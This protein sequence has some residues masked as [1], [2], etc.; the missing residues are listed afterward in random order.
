MNEH[1]SCCS[2][3]TI[4]REK[5]MDIFKTIEVRRS[6][7]KYKP[8]AV[9]DEDLKIILQ[10]ARLAPSARNAQPWRFIVVRDHKM[11]EFL[12]QSVGNQNFVAGA[13]VVVVVLG[14]SDIAPYWYLQD[15][16][17]ATEH[18]VLAATAL[19]YGSCWIGALAD[20]VPENTGKVKQALQIPEN[21]SIVCLVTI[22][23]PDENPPP[24]PRKNLQEICFDEMYGKPLK[25]H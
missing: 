18:L 10:A 16:M 24:R 13:S 9:S 2:T 7:R 1:T 19:G 8:E 21:L 15:P 25:F 6:V 11:K 5:N 3:S 22:G 20:W 12:A 17:I 4:N 14:D 23:I